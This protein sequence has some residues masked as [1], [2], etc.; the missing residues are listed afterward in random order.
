VDEICKKHGKNYTKSGTI[1][2]A[3]I[4]HFKQINDMSMM[5]ENKKMN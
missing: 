2:G 5:S 1:I 3:L 4:N